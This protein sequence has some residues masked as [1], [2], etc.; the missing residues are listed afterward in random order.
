V[1]LGVL[2]ELENA[3]LVTLADKLQRPRHL[4]DV[5]VR[6]GDDLQVHPVL[7]VLAE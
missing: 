7:L 5:A 1:D 3:G 6:T 2:D 4:R